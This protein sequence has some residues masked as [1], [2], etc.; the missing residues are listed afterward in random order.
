MIVPFVTKSDT[1]VLQSYL[2]GHCG[3][4]VGCH[5][6]R[7]ALHV[8]CQ[9]GASFTPAANQNLWMKRLVPWKDLSLFS[10]DTNCYSTEF[11]NMNIS[12]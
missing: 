2:P 12:M 9:L 10:V 4:C 3:M 6:C 1:D 8:C 5:C 11:P 7:F